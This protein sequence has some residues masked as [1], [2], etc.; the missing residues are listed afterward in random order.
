[1]QKRIYVTGLSMGGYGTWDVIGRRPDLFAAA[2]PVCG[3]GDETQ[4]AT[5]ARVPIWAFHGARD[6]V[7]KPARSWNMVAAL[8]K[9]GGHPGYTE[10]PDVGHDSWVPTYRDPVLFQWL[11]AQKRK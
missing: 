7:V 2:V 4:A 5:I 11:F 8:K 6:G 9:A 1:D 10:Y 3:G